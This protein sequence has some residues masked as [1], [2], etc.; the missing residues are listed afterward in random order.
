MVIV[1]VAPVTHGWEASDHGGRRA[2][3]AGLSHRGTE[4][5]RFTSGIQRRYLTGAPVTCPRATET[6]RRGVFLGLR[7]DAHGGFSHRGTEAPSLP[8]SPRW[9]SPSLLDGCAGA[10]PTGHEDTEAR[11]LSGYW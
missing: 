5:Q 7:F 10:L 4:A 2:S 6:R 3:Y 9:C 1:P 11:S 8:L